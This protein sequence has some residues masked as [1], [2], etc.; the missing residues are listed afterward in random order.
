MCLKETIFTKTQIRTNECQIFVESF[1]ILSAPPTIF[2]INYSPKKWSIVSYGEQYNSSTSYAI[3]IRTRHPSHCGV[4]RGRWEA[5]E[6][7]TS[8]VQEWFN[9]QLNV[10][11]RLVVVARLFLELENLIR[12]AARHL[13]SERNLNILWQHHSLDGAVQK[14]SAFDTNMQIRTINRHITFSTTSCQIPLNFI[15]CMYGKCSNYKFWQF[16]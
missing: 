1:W 5:V 6:Q 10:G 16:N 14:I 4:S 7:T 8:L 9:L 13:K 11:Q 3:H 2:I 12:P 15:S